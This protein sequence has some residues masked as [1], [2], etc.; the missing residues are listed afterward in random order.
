MNN[1]DKKFNE[2]FSDFFDNVK[3]MTEEERKLEK[4]KLE[5][6]K[7]DY[8]EFM[9]LFQEYGR[10]LPGGEN[11]SDKNPVVRIKEE[12]VNGKFVERAVTKDDLFND[13]FDELLDCNKSQDSGPKM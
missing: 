3:L 6:E 9:R 4:E 10:S 8:Q 13:L 1:S 11:A 5:R 7:A 12:V 2:I